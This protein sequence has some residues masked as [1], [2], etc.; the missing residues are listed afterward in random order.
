MFGQVI[1]GINM[2]TI[3]SLSRMSLIHIIFIRSTSGTA[4]E[5]GS[6]A[7][8]G[9]KPV[10][11]MLRMGI[12]Q[13]IKVLEYSLNGAGEQLCPLL[14]KSRAGGFFGVQ[15]KKIQQFILGGRGAF[16]N[17]ERNQFLWRE[18]SCTGVAHIAVS[19]S[20]FFLMAGNA[21]VIIFA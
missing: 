6:G 8:S 16:R 9:K 12:N 3:K 17:Q 5:C 11:Q 18:F 15:P 19:V 10:F 13:R 4:E 20:A 7:V 14:D 21:T 1:H 2:D